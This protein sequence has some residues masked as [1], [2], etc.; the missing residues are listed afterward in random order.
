MPA[1][2]YAGTV[3]VGD[4][5]IPSSV[6][7]Q[8]DGPMVRQITAAD[9]R[10]LVPARRRDA[11]KGSS[12]H[13]LVV[14]G[15]LGKTG[16]AALTACAALRSGAGLVTVA[17]PA[18]CASIVASFAP[19]IMT[20]PLAET[21]EGQVA[22]EAAEAV[23]AFDASVLAVG[24][25]LGR[26][27]QTTAFV[28]ELVR[29][30]RRPMVL[31]ADGLNAFEA[32]VE[33]L[34]SH[35]PIVV[36]PHPG[37]MARL[38][39]RTTAAVQADRLGAAGQFAVDRKLCVVLKGHGTVVAEPGGRLFVN[40][41][42]NPGMATAGMGDVLTGVIAAWLAQGGDPEASARLGVYLHGAAGDLAA[43]EL[44]ERGLVARDVI[45]RLPRACR[46]LS[47]T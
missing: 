21:A 45:D 25:G 40:T 16:A 32:H 13:V 22:A 38:T 24:P 8:V 11:H 31:D 3:V 23:L 35:A 27:A 10:G 34:S 39:G 46:T 7:G 9:C 17:T 1:A 36:T 4:I 44:G 43:A 28:Q 29:R 20:L 12:G 41:T 5:G 30:A 19:E 15:S 2:E 47:T 14:A 26:S 18:S 37:E 6:I 42:G 33:R